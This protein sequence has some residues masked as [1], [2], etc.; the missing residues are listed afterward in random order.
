MVTSTRHV[1]ELA[2]AP[3]QQLSLHAVAKEILQPK[4]T[5]YGFEWKDQ[6]GIEGTGF[7]RALR[8]LLTAHLPSLL[9]S[10][11]TIIAEGI[12]SD[13]RLGRTARNTS[14]VHIFPMTK[15]V[16]AR[17]NCLIF[18]GPGLSQNN[19]FNAAA[20][21][22]PQAVVLAAEVLRIMP[23][24]LRPFV[25]RIATS[26]HRAARTLMKH[27]GPVVQ[28]RLE[29]RNCPDGAPKPVHP[30]GNIP[31]PMLTSIQVDCMQWLI[32]TSPRKIPWT[33]ERMIGEI[34]AL[35][36]GSVHQLAM[37][38]TYAIQDLCLQPY[39]MQET[40]SELHRVS[41]LSSFVDPESLPLLDAFIQESMRVNP[42]D[43][44][45]G[46]RKAIEPFRFSDG[47]L[48]KAGDWVCLPQ[49]AMLRDER[50]YPQP[51]CFDPTRFLRRQKVQDLWPVWGLGNATCPTNTQLEI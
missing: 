41:Q 6:R 40:R 12:E 26:G 38:T 18:F 5:M 48:V 16:I 42:S 34:L 46:R 37:T 33:P 20:L 19:E 51:A 44:I 47:L 28:A 25:A 10:L 22:F 32:D 36:F 3:F 21:E 45:S 9:P 24:C 30:T 13:I 2:N 27:L 11:R 14:Q 23:Q 49:Q 7:V 31:E 29:A 4:Y 1:Q 39:W 43:A 17:A 8:S 50:L 35:W 15:R